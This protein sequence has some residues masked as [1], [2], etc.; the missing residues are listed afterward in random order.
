MGGYGNGSRTNGI[1][2]VCYWLPDYIFVS[3]GLRATR[4]GMH[5]VSNR[6]V[7]SPLTPYGFYAS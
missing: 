2:G 3:N 5:T 4:G 1:G 7:E 6:V